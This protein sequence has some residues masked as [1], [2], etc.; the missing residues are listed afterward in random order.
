[1]ETSRTQRAAVKYKE[2]FAQD[3][4]A[5]KT[6]PE[7]MTILQSVIFGEVFYI[8]NLNDKTRELITITALTTNQTLPQLIP[9]TNAAL[10]VGV[11]PIEIREVIYQCAPFI[12]FP[13]VLNA[14]E[15]VNKVFEQKGIKVP[16]EMQG[17][18]TEASR[19]E[20][21]VEQQVPLYG[22]KMKQ[23]MQDLPAGL[24]NELADLLTESCFGD[25]YIRNGLDLKTRELMVFC[26]LATLGGT[27][28]QMASHAAGNMKAGN[29]KETLISAMVQLY[30]YVGFPR[31][32][33]A[34]YT[35]REVKEQ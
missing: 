3:I 28:K 2:L 8:G 24:G 35:I 16:L 7:L 26:A 20:K 10:N 11:T 21:G 18:V 1:M 17:T 6:D 15:V 32:A 23:N 4:T 27:E 13:K 14:M 33:N 34:I 29:N 9:H 25:F 5:S 19:H 30:P 22:D 12:G 31:A